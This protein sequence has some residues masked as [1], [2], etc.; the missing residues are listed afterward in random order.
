MHFPTPNNLKVHLGGTMVD[1]PKLMI[2]DEA[3]SNVDIHTKKLIQVGLRKL[4]EGKTS[5][6]HPTS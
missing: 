2:L 1:Q 5:S 4:R 3:L 6:P